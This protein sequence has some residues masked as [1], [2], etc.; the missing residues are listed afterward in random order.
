MADCSHCGATLPEEIDDGTGV[1]CSECGHGQ[2]V[3]DGGTEHVDPLEAI[4]GQTEVEIECG[5][6]GDA[7]PDCDGWSET[8]ELDE[9]ANYTDEGRIELPGF[10]W[11]CPE[12][13]NPHEF[14]VEGIR[15][16]N[17]V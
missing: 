13:G 9:P 16:T 11:E 7:T 17:L 14:V 2:L 12:C 1:Y 6:V 10:D 3:T 4:D 5:V 8:V 15:V